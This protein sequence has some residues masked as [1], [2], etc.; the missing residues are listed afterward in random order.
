MYLG[1]ATRERN[2]EEESTTEL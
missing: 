1:V 2:H